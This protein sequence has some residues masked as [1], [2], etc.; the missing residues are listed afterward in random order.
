[1]GTDHP[2]GQEHGH[3]HHHIHSEEHKRKIVNRLSRAI[4]H[5]E[6]VRRMVENDADCN[7]VLVQLMAVKSAINNTGREIAKE[8][9][10]HCIAEAIAEGNYEEVE[11]FKETLEKLIQ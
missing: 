10:T 7:D 2:H 4:G 11:E 5:L 1:M 8:H 3:E 6:S 9:L